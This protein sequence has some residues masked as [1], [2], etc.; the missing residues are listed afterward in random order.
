MKRQRISAVDTAW[1]RMDSPG[2]LMMIC[3]VLFFRTR[4]DIARLRDVIAK[5]FLVFPRFRQ[6]PVETVAVSYWEDDGAVD[7]EQHV[8]GVALPG[9]AGPRELQALVSRLMSTPLDPARP[10]WQFHLVENYAGGSAIV[11]RIHHCYADGIALVRVMLSMTDASADGPP[12]MPFAPRAKRNA[13][14]DPFATLLAP[15]SGALALARRIGAALIDEGAAL[16][17]DP[18][19]AAVLA[20]R[21]GEFA[22]EIARLALMAQ[23]TPT[24]FKGVPGGA[25]RVAWAAPIPLDEVKTIGRALGASVNDVLL[26]CAAGALRAYLLAKGDATNDVMIRALVP[27]NLRPAEQAWR[28]GN[29]FGL[30]FLDL[31]VGVENPIERLY[32][33]RAHMNALKGSQQPILSLGLLAAM[34]AG[35]RILH[36]AL[37]AALARNATAVMTNVPGPKVPLYL[38][39]SRIDSLMFWVPQA[40]DIGMGVSILS[41]DGHVQFGVTTDRKLCPDPARIAVGFGEQF[42]QLVLTTLMSPWPREGD[43][44]PAVA[45]RAVASRAR[46]SRA[47]RRASPSRPRA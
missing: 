6:R 1:L 28:L 47:S 35:P 41:Y 9:R 43:L 42:E 22:V 14:D 16:W 31:P 36:D 10:R 7:L 17:Q 32:A 4:I 44:D 2:N 29:R 12:A 18:E 15:V 23:D 34:G 21:G 40:G 38:A 45:A 27:V 20:E 25:K 11:M 13:G 46:P 3:G 30:V 37:L 19:K 33:V 39:G 26:A 5:R 8:V 24:R